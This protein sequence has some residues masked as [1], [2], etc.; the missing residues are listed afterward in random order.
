MPPCPKCHGL[1]TPNAPTCD[2]DDDGLV[3]A[4]SVACINCGLVLSGH[5]RVIHP[6]VD[7]PDLIAG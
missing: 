5:L 3:E 4:E 7:Q 6:V 2:W 1:L